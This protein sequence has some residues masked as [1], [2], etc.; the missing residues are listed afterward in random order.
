M[1]LGH[2]SAAVAVP[3]LLREGPFEGR[4]HLRLQGLYL[5]AVGG[6]RFLD[7]GGPSLDLL[8]EPGQF[9]LGLAQL[10]HGGVMLR[11]PGFQLAAG[12]LDRAVGGLELDQ[13]RG[14]GHRQVRSRHQVTQ[15]PLHPL[16]V[17]GGQ[18]GVQPDGEQL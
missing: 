13:G 17:G 6:P 7:S 8:L 16:L 18:A 2:V 14:V 9:F 5:L 15:L 12:L 3:S 1:R 4:Q 10:L 11:R